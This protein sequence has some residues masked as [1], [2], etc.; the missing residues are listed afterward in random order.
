MKTKSIFTLLVLAL[1]AGSISAQDFKAFKFGICLGFAKPAGAG[2]SGGVLLD[3]EP[4]Y[5]LS[6]DFALGLRVQTAFMARVDP[7][8]LSA[9]I[10]G[11]NSYVLN[12]QYYLAD[13]G[14]R[15]VVGLGVGLFQVA[16]VSATGTGT[17]VAVAN[18]IGFPIRLGFDAGHFMMA[19]EYHIL[20]PGES[21]VVVGTPQKIN[22]NYLGIKLGG[23][24][25]GGK[26]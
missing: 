2:S 10:S 25:G 8:G 21:T 6:D 17:G 11:Q 3:V 24:F 13:G 18:E 20:T 16:N 7:S 14:F 12:G 15:P 19:F 4:A 5:R 1:M 9:G 23:F 22:N 26:K